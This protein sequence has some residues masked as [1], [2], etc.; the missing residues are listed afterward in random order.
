VGE[1]ASSGAGEKTEMSGFA[2][3]R[4][5]ALGKVQLRDQTGFTMEIYDPSIEGIRVDGMVGFELFRRFVV[6]LDY[7]AQT[8]TV[9]DAAHF[10][11]TGAGTAVP[12]KFYDHLPYVQGFIDDLPARFDIDTGSRSEL[13]ITSAFVASHKLRDKYAKGVSTI[14]GWGVGGATRSYVVRIPSM[15][16]GTVQMQ[17]VVAG[18][19][20]TKGGSISDANFDG[21]IGSGF[22]K[23]FVVTFDYSHQVMYLKPLDPQPI[24]AGRFDRS[25]MWINAGKDA[26]VVT[27]VA[28]GSPAA[29]AGLA[30]GDEITVLDGKPAVA[31]HLSDARTLLR[32]LPAGTE[33]AVTYK[34]KGAERRATIKLRDQI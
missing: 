24:D 15:A 32:A 23:R 26:Y 30:E 10:D 28:A 25:G 9:I 19:S 16:L 33:V 4:Q 17:S 3:Y 18:L 34:R 1:S 8:M 2:R 29:V 6:K 31:E 13:D 27:S 5:I 12:F 22:L 11:A 14:T 7:G 21:N 20:E